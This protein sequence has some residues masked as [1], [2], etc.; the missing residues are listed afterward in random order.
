MVYLETKDD[1]AIL[2]LSRGVVEGEWEVR[3]GDAEGEERKEQSRHHPFPAEIGGGGETQENRSCVGLHG[4]WV[5][6]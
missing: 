4:C 6:T 1:E 5:F 3:Q 2:H